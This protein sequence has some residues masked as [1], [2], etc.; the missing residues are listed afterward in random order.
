MIAR[1]QRKL[2]AVSAVSVL[3]VFALIFLLLVYFSGRQL[4]R[5]MDTL[6][7]AISIGGGAFPDFEPADP[8]RPFPEADVIDEE[9]RF[10][11]RFFVV[12]LG[13]TDRIL[14][15]NVDAVSSSAR[16][17]WRNTPWPRWSRTAI[18]AGCRTTASSW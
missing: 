3:L 2:V 17:R 8:A 13:E 1:L 12:W 5:T 9:T 11:T 15:V 4:D 14:R 18:G 6:T 10:S 7:D 16:S